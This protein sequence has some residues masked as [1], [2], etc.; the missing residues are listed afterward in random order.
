MNICFAT[1]SYPLNGSATSGVGS[2]VQAIAHSLIDAGNT[3]SV[4]NL[5]KFER[6]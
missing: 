5:T 6:R 3:V 4:L 1:V 2:Q